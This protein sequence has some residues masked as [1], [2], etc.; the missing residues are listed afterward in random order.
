MTTDRPIS[1]IN[2]VQL[3]RRWGVSP[4]TL[5]KWRW[6][7]KGPRFLKLGGKVAYRIADVIA[8]ETERLRSSTPAM[9]LE[10]KDCRR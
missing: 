4:R 5:E 9:M 7:G 10:N 6:R 3:S 8:Y 1:H 2:Q